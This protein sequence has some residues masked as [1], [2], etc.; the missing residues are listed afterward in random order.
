MQRLGGQIRAVQGVVL[1]LDMGA[2]LA[3]GAALGVS[4]MLAADVLPEVEAIMVE[5]LNAKGGGSDG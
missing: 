5:K 2:A 1:G 3:M 4:A